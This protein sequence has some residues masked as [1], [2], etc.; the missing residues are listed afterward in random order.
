MGAWCDNNN[1]KN[2]QNVT[3]KQAMSFLS[4]LFYQ[5]IHKHELPL[6]LPKILA[7]N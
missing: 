1:M 3:Y 2:P 7:Y 6:A 4:H 5:G